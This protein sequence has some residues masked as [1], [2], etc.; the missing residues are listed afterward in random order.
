M[1][2][3]NRSRIRQRSTGSSLSSNNERLPNVVVAAMSV[4]LLLPTEAQAYLGPTHCIKPGTTATSIVQSS[5]GTGYSTFNHLLFDMVS[6]SSSFQSGQVI[7]DERLTFTIC[8][9]TLIDLDDTSLPI[10][11]LP[12]DVPRLT[13]Q[14]GQH[15][16]SIR[17][18]NDPSTSCTIRGGGKR[19]SSSV[20]WN[21][22]PRSQSY[23]TDIEGIVGGGTT[24]VAQ[25][26]VYGERDRKSVV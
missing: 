2:P 17:G 26:Y 13:L 20:N 11:F 25:I 7:P 15:G 10:G 6:L 21:T 16:H 9:G 8:P 19:K 22:N 18:N 23:K 3:F 24:S 14:C 5:S 4:L 1:S 12:I